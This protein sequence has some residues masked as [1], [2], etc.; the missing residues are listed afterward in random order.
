MEKRRLAR[1]RQSLARPAKDRQTGANTLNGANTFLTRGIT[2]PSFGEET[3]L[4]ELAA[5]ISPIASFIFLRKQTRIF[6][7][8]GGDAFCIKQLHLDLPDPL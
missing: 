5:H 1:F 8:Q 4:K 7:P 3:F 2:F 6:L